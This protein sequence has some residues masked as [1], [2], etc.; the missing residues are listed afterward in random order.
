MSIDNVDY[1]IE[2]TQC[3]GQRNL[4]LCT[5]YPSPLTVSN[6]VFRGFSGVTSRKYQPQIA[7]FA[8]SSKNVCGMIS[9]TDIKVVSPS[10]TRDAYCLNQDEAKLDVHCTSRHF[11]FN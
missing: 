7:A 10:G 2:I 1:A 8:C 6:I 5:E 3:Y 9:A 4:T 11:G